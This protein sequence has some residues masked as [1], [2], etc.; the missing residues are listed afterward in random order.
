MKKHDVYES[1]IAV[2]KE[3]AKKRDG[4]LFVIADKSRLKNIYKPLFP[5]IH[6]SFYI[7]K[8][9][10]LK[11]IEKLATLDGAVL[12]S[13]NGMLIA[14]GAKLNKSKPIH[15]HGTKHAA[16][17][18]ITSYIK[19]ATAV[20]ISEEDNFIKV[21]Q[22]GKIILEMD[23]Y[24]NPKSLQDKI[25]SFISEGDTALLTAAGVSTA[26][27]GSA[28]VG[29]LAVVG[30]TY[31]AIKTASGIIKKNWYALINRKH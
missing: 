17:S 14:Y 18:G 30:G 28:I 13:N 8:E 27:L 4:A 19:N 5:Q 22:H 15:G 6:K 1:I 3:I 31:L 7:N 20:L 29:P 24:E 16:A 26:I 11:V 12:I 10:S 21:F 23:S 9:G 2:S 25:I